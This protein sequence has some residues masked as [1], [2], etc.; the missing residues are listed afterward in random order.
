MVAGAIIGGA[1]LSAGVG[2]ASSSAASGAQQDSA[3]AATNAQLQM[4]NTAQQNLSP[5]NNAGQMALSNLNGLLGYGGAG[6]SQQMQD[7]L[8]NMPG[9]QFT[10][11]QGLKAVQNSAAARGLGSSGAALKGAASYATGLAQSNYDQYYN[12]LLG[13][14]GLGE[15]AAAGVGN[16]AVQTGQG[17]AGSTIAGGNA[18]AS[19]ILG[20]GNS[21][22]NAVG[23]AGNFY[24]T[25]QLLNGSGGG[26]WQNVSSGQATSGIN[27][28]I[29][30]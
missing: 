26:S 17:I 18:A 10:L 4:F 21:I 2:A 28:L 23:Q 16:A 15:N 30:A 1:V 12:Q 29:T 5:Y 24:L 19:G 8:N 27:P 3:S 11:G 6:S 20:V 7:T 14:A 22:N 25:N 9:Y 13:A